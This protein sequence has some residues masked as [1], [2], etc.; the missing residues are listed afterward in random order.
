MLG[1]ITGDLKYVTDGRGKRY[2]VIL[3]FKVWK[4]I[5]E[6]LESLRE[7]HQILTGLQQAC[8]EVKRQESDDLDEQSIEGFLD[9]L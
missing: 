7:K 5:V 1:D 3:P 8:R 4:E 9:E 2:E 6:E